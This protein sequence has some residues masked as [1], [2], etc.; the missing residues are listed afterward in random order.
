MN[1]IPSLPPSSS[2]LLHSSHLIEPPQA[3][4]FL[5]CHPL[6]SPAAKSNLNGSLLRDWCKTRADKSPPDRSTGSK[7]RR[8]ANHRGSKSA[9]T[10][11]T[12]PPR[13][14]RCS[15]QPCHNVRNR[16]AH[17]SWS[18][19][20]ASLLFFFP[21]SVSFFFSFFQPHFHSAR[22]YVSLCSLSDRRFSNQV[23]LSF[24]PME[25][26]LGRDSKSGRYVLGFEWKQW[27]PI[28]GWIVRNEEDSFS[29]FFLD[30]WNS[31]SDI[32]IELEVFWKYLFSLVV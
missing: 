11:F 27:L 10:R 13:N 9:L 31:L 7:I 6:W 29:Y 3:S 18:T 14:R 1:S 28:S 16:K 4:S 26:K 21:L 17:S 22:E 5:P 24:A 2:S 19:L 30:I 12:K 25:T 8:E 20:L 32:M 23:G 15:G